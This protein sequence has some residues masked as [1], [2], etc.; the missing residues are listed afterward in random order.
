M[1]NVVIRK[2]SINDLDMLLRF[3]QGVIEAERPS[4]STLKSGLI[5]YYDI[6]EMITASHIRLVVAELDHI[7]IGSGYARIENSKPYL[8]HD[9]H[10]YLGFMYVVPAHRGKGI[11]KRI[12]DALAEWAVSQNIYEMRLEVYNDNIPAIN[13]YEK[14]GFTRHMIEMRLGLDKN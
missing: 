4:D 6:E 3:E 12:I 8:K 14:I 10:A 5:H 9:R 1:D 13:A 11:N 2:A 7:I